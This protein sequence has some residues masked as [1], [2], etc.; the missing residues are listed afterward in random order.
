M[1]P[2]KNSVFVIADGLNPFFAEDIGTIRM[3]I[4]AEGWFLVRR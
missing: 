3:L 2:L 1:A 4:T